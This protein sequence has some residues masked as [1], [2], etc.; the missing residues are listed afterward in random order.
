MRFTSLGGIVVCVGA[1]LVG[2]ARAQDAYVPDDFASINA[3]ISQAAD[4]DGDG[5][6]EIRLRRGTYLENV[7][8]DRDDVSLSGEDRESTIIQGD[9][10]ADT[11]AVSN[12]FAVVVETLRVT[13]GGT[14]A[15]GVS[16]YRSTSCLVDNCLVEG[17][18]RGITL[19]QSPG[20]T[21]ASNVVRSNM[22]AGI[23]ATR[24]GG[25]IVRENVVTLNFRQ[26]L[27]VVLNDGATLVDNVVSD[28]RLDGIRVGA[29]SWCRT[30]G[31]RCERNGLNGILTGRGVEN[32]FFS[33][34]CSAN[35]ESGLRMQETH[36]FV[37]SGN[38]FTGNGDYG[39]R[40]RLWDADDYDAGAPGVQPAYGANDC[41]DNEDGPIRSD[42]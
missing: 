7:V 40:R 24:S 5:V 9:G 3:A 12:A 17:N 22:G 37:I 26:G 21:I 16:L 33:N 34:Q 27:D 31:N 10:V 38:A 42:S 8:V 1:A 28:N 13:G 30:T 23:R 11:L 25:V 14:A 20:N 41:E 32:L 4:I 15:N 18:R 36:S 2:R 39:I 19:D 6:L 35:V 29:G